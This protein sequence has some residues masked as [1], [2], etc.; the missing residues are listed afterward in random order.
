[1]TAGTGH[2]RGAAAAVL[3][4]VLACGV[5][6]VVGQDL[7]SAVAEA[8]DGY[9]RFEYAARP[10][11]CGELSGGVCEEGPV[12]IE[13][14]VRAGTVFDLLVEVGGRWRTRSRDV[15]DLGVVDPA[16]ASAFLFR[17]AETSNT[18]A[19]ER[20]L[21]PATLARGVEAWPR[22]LEIARG[23]ARTGIRRSAVFW[24]GQEAGERVTEGLASVVVD[25][26]E[27]EVREHAIFAL[28][29]REE[30]SAV[31]ALISVARD[32]PEPALRKRA[33]FWL[34]QRGDDPRVLDLLEELLRGAG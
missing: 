18:A 12:R 31:E 7:W 24:L 30:A 15:T 11:V 8:P 34:G 1:V 29:Q 6:E 16:D 13:M 19:G 3:V 20:A 22:L 27:L 5:G 25:D 17:L 4:L 10:G 32:S 33:I 14:R 23:G 9:V 28:A 26:G 2:R 21:F